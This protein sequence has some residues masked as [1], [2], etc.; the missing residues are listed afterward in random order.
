MNEATTNIT[1]EQIAAFFG[2]QP[3][4]DTAPMRGVYIKL[5]GDRWTLTQRPAERELAGSYDRTVAEGRQPSGALVYAIQQVPSHV[6]DEQV[7]RLA[8]QT[9][10]IRHYGVANEDAWCSCTYAELG[11]GK[12]VDRKY[13]H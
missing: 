12:I 7:V 6:T 2:V 1:G 8:N 3:I 5:S 13:R 4:A 10:L 11:A 9:T